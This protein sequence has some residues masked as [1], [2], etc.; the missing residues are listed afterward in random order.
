M[1]PLALP[2]RRAIA[3]FV[4]K[5]F[6]PI[7]AEREGHARDSNAPFDLIDFEPSG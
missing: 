6:H 1:A 4:H 2:P 3:E 7:V 5:Q